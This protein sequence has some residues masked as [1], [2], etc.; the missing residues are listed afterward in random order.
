V[1]P[2]LHG[3]RGTLVAVYRPAAVISHY[4]ASGN[5]TSLEWIQTMYAVAMRDG[6]VVGEVIC[7]RG[8]LIVKKDGVVTQEADLSAEYTGEWQF[9]DV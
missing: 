9:A 4:D 2:V 3:F 8:N 1:P 6:Q 5:P 7:H